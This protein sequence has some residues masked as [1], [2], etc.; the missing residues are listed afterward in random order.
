MAEA[1]PVPEEIKTAAA[2]TESTED[3]APKLVLDEPTGELVSKK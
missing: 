2:T 3:V 1:N